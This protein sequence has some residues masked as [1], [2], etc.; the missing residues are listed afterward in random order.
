[1]NTLIITIVIGVISFLAF[2][3]FTG[4][5]KTHD[6]KSV[7]EKISSTIVKKASMGLEEVADGI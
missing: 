6:E 4:N 7:L 3:Y 5:N 1:M 2:K